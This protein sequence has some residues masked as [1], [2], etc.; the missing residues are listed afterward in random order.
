MEIPK[1]RDGGMGIEC[2]ELLYSSGEFGRA[3]Q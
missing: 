2:G 1:T 3:L